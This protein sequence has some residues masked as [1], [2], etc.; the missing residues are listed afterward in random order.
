MHEPPRFGPS[1][2]KRKAQDD[3][4]LKTGSKMFQRHSVFT[5]FFQL[6]KAKLL[7]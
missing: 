2:G 4:V 6:A 3:Q 7:Q 5:L 1:G